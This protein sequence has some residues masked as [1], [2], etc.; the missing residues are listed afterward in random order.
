MSMFK[1]LKGIFVIEAEGSSQESATP[2]VSNSNSSKTTSETVNSGNTI[3]VN[4]DKSAAGAKPD[5]K[6]VDMLLKAIEANNIEG[7]D[8]L[9]FKQ[10][11]QSLTKIETDE[12]KRFQNAFAMAQTMGLDKKKLFDSANRYIAVL[13]D[14]EAKFADAFTKQKSA[15]VIQREQKAE[16]LKND[17]ISKEA[18]IKK[19]QQ[20]IENSKKELSK[21]ESEINESL[22]KVESTKDGFYA[23]YNMVLGQIKN[24]VEKI[25]QYLT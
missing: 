16:S 19:L 14:E 5:N 21:F 4:I 7:F 24:D 12:A 15:Q 13:G 9:E 17:I 18:Q 1:K 20:E 10:S 25:N 22:A 3:S 11:L 2:K 23:S 6:F 8:Y